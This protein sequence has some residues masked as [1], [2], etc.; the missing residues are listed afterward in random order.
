[1]TA[2]MSANPF[3]VCGPLPKGTTVL[4][5]SAG[6]GKTF[7][8]AALAVRYVA[9]GHA[10]L[11]ELLLVTFGRAATREL[12][13]RVRERLVGVEQAL[14]DPGSA[15][16]DGDSLVRLLA[17]G[18][19]EDVALRRHRIAVALADFD[20]ATIDTTHAFCQHMLTGLGIMADDDPGGTFVENIDDLVVEVVEDLYVRQWGEPGS[21]PPPRSY[22][23]LLE[24]ARLVV[25]DA[26][27]VLDPAATSGDELTR[28]AQDVREEVMARKRL[29]GL[30]D[31]DD[32]LSRLH[33]SL[34][35]PVSGEMARER[36][37]PRYRVVMV[38]E[39]QD[40][41]PVQWAILELL[42]HQHVTLVL[43]GDPK[44]SIYAFRGGDVT[45]YLSARAQASSEGTLARNWRSDAGLVTGLDRLFGRA[46]LGDPTITPG[47]VEAEHQGSRLK[48]RPGAVRVRVV[49]RQLSSG[50]STSNAGV[51]VI[52]DLIARDLARDIVGL[53]DNGAE[54]EIRGRA[55]GPV[56]PGDIAVLVGTNLQATMMH[57]ALLATGVPAVLSGTL[58]VFST[59][60]AKEW[61]VLLRALDRPNYSLTAK[62]AALTRLVGWDAA[63]LAAAGDDAMDELGP[64]L[65]GW[66]HVLR[67][68]GVPALLEAVTQDANVSA[69]LLARTDGE[70]LLTDLRHIAE[71]LHT[72]VTV[73]HIGANALLEWLSRQIQLALPDATDER[74][75]RLESDAD[76]V[77]V[78]TIHR[79]KGLEFPITYV[80]FAWDKWPRS[81]TF[82]RFHAEDGT[83][84]LFV[85]AD[86]GAELET[87]Q[88]A[89][90]EEEA[91]EDLREVYVALTR[92]Q[93]QVVTWWSASPKNTIE[94]PLHRLLFGG[95]EPGEQP[96][97][98]VPV[99]S[100]DRAVERL[101]EMS[102][103]TGGE[104]VVET[105]EPLPAVA[106]RWH[107]PADAASTLS[108]ATFDRSLDRSW[109][110]VS[111]SGLTAA[112]YEAAHGGTHEAA[113]A[114]EPEGPVLDDEPNGSPVADVPTVDLLE[115]AMRAERS[116]MADL[117]GGTSFGIVVHSVLERVDNGA[118][119]L[120]AE[121][122]E[123]SRDVLSRWS[124]VTYGPDELGSALLPALETSLGPLAAGRRLRDV[125]NRDQLAELDFELPLVGGDLLAAETTGAVSTG[126][127]PS[128]R[129]IA[130][131]LRE[132][133]PADDPFAPYPD[134]LDELD[135]RSLRGYLVG[136]IDLVLRIDDGERSRYLV[137]DYK[138]NWL[139]GFEGDTLSAWHYRPTA[140][141]DAML[142][143]HYP[144]QLLLYLVGLHRYLRWR[145]PGY[146]PDVHLGGGLYLFLRGMCGS[147]TP[148]V[149]RVPCG[150][151]GWQPPPALVDDLSRLLAGGAA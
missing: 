3:D 119:D 51:P 82:P 131:L 139:G 93:C 5:A 105:V 7:T 111:Y 73:E 42:F 66:A 151:F 123:R 81:A 101:T 86:G 125:A 52:R 56:R 132:R 94:A 129:A 16:T 145:Q 38:D 130:A 143:A 96:D 20:A 65:S 97:D 141:T 90:A 17:D 19:D 70:R 75:R 69:R 57:E 135:D 95:H 88:E 35:D 31:F 34:T 84:S 149:D 40:T 144:L 80:P 109:R 85:K 63:R 110:R 147:D 64:M 100:D 74:S 47:P 146:D 127:G 1:M 62:T 10:L 6:T 92:A 72:A 150:V 67:T 126:D 43:I 13:E 12:R 103:D 76:A 107:P 21:D 50:G 79:S 22:K 118:P 27:V 48:G 32:L 124:T 54:L 55:D 2:V 14:A 77:Q 39:F 8:I 116:P 112:A 148:V 106:A 87:Y 59:P 23:D 30:R 78:V 99:L 36:I 137:A 33:R 102:R 49:T 44:Q 89:H 120:G 46:A 108:V 61:L 11:N 24:L 91:G 53:L 117:P 41:D 29:R 37:R 98:R 113:I 140:L 128:V 134:L 122:V 28:F 15:R 26:H 136:S 133:L 18:T 121:L 142:A 115:E 114:S 83:R 68:R 104:L 9:E 71:A 4:E 138:T 25:G 60:M 45:T 58:S